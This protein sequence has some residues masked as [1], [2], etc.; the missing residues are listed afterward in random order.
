MIKPTPDTRTFTH[1]DS[2]ATVSARTLT[3]VGIQDIG[4]ST[5]IVYFVISSIENGKQRVHYIDMD[6]VDDEADICK[7]MEYLS[8]MKK[9]HVLIIDHVTLFNRS[10]VSKIE[11]RA[12]GILSKILLIETGFSASSR[13]LCNEFYFDKNLQLNQNECKTIWIE[14]L[15]KVKHCL[16]DQNSFIDDLYGHCENRFTLTPWLLH[17]VLHYMVGRGCRYDPSLQNGK[18]VEYFMLR[19][20]Q[21]FESGISNFCRAVNSE[22]MT[23]EKELCS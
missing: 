10:I 13:G 23:D 5:T 14:C 12:L 18:D 4:I 7:V 19:Y 20:M 11:Q 8:S 15:K 22:E 3:L 6:L 1:D 2:T 21:S 9:E 17:R 16:E